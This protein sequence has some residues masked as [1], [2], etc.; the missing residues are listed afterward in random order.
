[1]HTIRKE[2]ELRKQFGF[3]GDNDVDEC[4]LLSDTSS[5]NSSRFSG[6]S[7]R[8]GKSHRSSK[9]RRKHERKLLNLKEGN[10]FEDIALI[11]ALYALATNSFLQQDHIRSICKVL[12]ELQMDGQGSTLQRVFGELLHYIQQSLDEIWIPEMIT[13]GQL[14]TDGQIDYVQYQDEQHYTLISRTH[15]MCALFSV[16]FNSI[17]FCFTEPHQRFKPQLNAISW[18][19]EALK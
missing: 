12:I 4:D 11:D 9:N 8:T 17:F 13:S 6:S 15:T 18:E 16:G 2:K 19:F 14:P 3:A 5:M 1:M 10:P 7:G